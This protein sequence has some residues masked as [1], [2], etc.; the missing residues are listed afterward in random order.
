MASPCYLP[1]KLA[2]TIL[3]CVLPPRATAFC[4]APLNFVRIVFRTATS[5]GGS[6]CWGVMIGAATTPAVRGGLRFKVSD[7]WK[8]R[9]GCGSFMTGK[10]SHGGTQRI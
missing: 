1:T 4:L 7:V 10:K 6:N 8:Q 9:F 2:A 3:F 5:V